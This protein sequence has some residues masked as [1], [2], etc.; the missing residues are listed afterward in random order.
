[1]LRA[2]AAYTH[3]RLT[4]VEDSA[5]KFGFSDSQESR[6]AK[7]DLDAESV[8]VAHHRFKPG[9]RQPFG[10]HHDDAEEVYV[11]LSGSGRIALDDD[12]VELQPLDA[13]RVAPQVMRAFEAGP[14]G[15]EVIA[16]GPRREGDG[17]IVPGWWPGE[18]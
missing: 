12:L 4:D 1:M 6:F 18:G 5:P 16:F 13:V 3:T 8:G 7:D 10:H 2:M 11:V 9:V 15:L 17:E 14:E